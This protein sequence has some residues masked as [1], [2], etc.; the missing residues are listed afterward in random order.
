MTDKRKSRRVQRRAPRTCSA[1]F[2]KTMQDVRKRQA[3]RIRKAGKHVCVA[4][5]SGTM[6]RVT[7]RGDRIL[8]RPVVVMRFYECKVCGRDMKPN[9]GI[10]VSDAKKG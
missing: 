9:I 4:L 1:W 8:K 3:E 2:E 6:A 5:C 10:C 7:G